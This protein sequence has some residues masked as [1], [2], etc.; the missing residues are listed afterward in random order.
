MSKT[1]LIDGGSEAGIWLEK[2]V[3]TW[4]FCFT[5]PS[6][7]PVSDR[8]ASGRVQYHVAATVL[9]SGSYLRR[10]L[11]DQKQVWVV[12]NPQTESSTA[13]LQLAVHKETHSKFF[14]P[15]AL[16]FKRISSSSP[17]LFGSR[18]L[19]L[20]HHLISLSSRYAATLVSVFVV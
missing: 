18:S 17:L 5:V 13:V 4:E 12:C 20:H 14:G 1:L 7:S 8:S 2:G 10:D 3:S 9:G 19:S 15:L 11:A 6:T 16:A